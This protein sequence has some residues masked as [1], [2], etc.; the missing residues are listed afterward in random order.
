LQS[1]E[2][3]KNFL[4]S[5]LN[6]ALTPEQ[7]YS[8]KHAM[9]KFSRSANADLPSSQR[10]SCCAISNFPTDDTYGTSAQA[11]WKKSSEN[12]HVHYGAKVASAFAEIPQANCCNKR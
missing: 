2:P 6:P 12:D 4:E 11:S 1:N 7:D 9:L 3:R 5:L 8:D 10:A